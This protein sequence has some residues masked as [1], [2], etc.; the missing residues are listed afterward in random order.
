MAVA[1]NEILENEGVVTYFQPIMAVKSRTLFGVE[2]LSRGVEQGSGRIIPPYQLFM[3]ATA[4]DRIFELEGL[5]RKKALETFRKYHLMANDSLLFLNFEVSVLDQG[6]EGAGQL[7]QLAEQ[8][9]IPTERVVIEITES[10]VENTSALGAFIHRHRTAGFRIAL[11]DIGAGHSNLDRIALFKPDILKVDASLIR[12]LELDET[13]QE[14]FRSVANLAF[15]TGARVLAEGVETAAEGL[16]CLE[17]G[18]ELIQGYYLGRPAEPG[19]ELSAEGRRT[20]E[21]LA[22][23]FRKTM[24]AKFRERRAQRQLREKRMERALAALQGAQPAVFDA[25]LPADE[26]FYVL[27]RQ[28]RQ[29][30]GPEAPGPAGGLARPNIRGTDHSCRE[31]FYLAAEAG[32]GCHASEPYVSTA[33]GRPCITLTQWF[34]DSNGLE[35]LLCLDV[36]PQAEI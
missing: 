24:L 35:H 16:A 36:E 9:G 14:I 18:A 20:T 6:A 23:A 3:A 12:G 19:K 26:G 5:C 21:A 15:K 4:E 27:D 30:S 22:E 8:L 32:P 7:L 28:G 13:K 17:L 33:T 11:D 10:K 25:L 34:R 31:Y 29:V 2:A 1:I